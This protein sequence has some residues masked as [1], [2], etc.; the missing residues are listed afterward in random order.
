MCKNKR[1]LK[2]M[3]NQ[4][5]VILV[6]MYDVFSFLLVARLNVQERFRCLLKGLQVAVVCGPQWLE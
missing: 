2:D 6:C 1:G 3:P 5:H 4:C